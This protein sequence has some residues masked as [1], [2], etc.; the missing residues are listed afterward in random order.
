MNND[1]ITKLT[2]AIKKKREESLHILLKTL[3]NNLNDEDKK[4]KVSN[5]LLQAI[6]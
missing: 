5:R 6:F 2:N 1:D 4:I 3:K